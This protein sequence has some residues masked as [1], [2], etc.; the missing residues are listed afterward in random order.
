MIILKKSISTAHLSKRELVIYDT[1]LQQEVAS[2][3]HNHF[4]SW[5]DWQVPYQ[6]SLEAF[7]HLINE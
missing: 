6:E 1:F 5:P 4:K 3:E 2:V 7:Q